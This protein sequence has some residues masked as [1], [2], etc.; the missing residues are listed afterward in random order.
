MRYFIFLI[1]CFV[2]NSLVSQTLI[3]SQPGTKIQARDIQG[4]LL[5]LIYESDI[6]DGI[7]NK[8]DYFTLDK[9]NKVIYFHLHMNNPQP[10]RDLL[11]KIDYSGNSLVELKNF[12]SPTSMVYSQKEN[13]IYY[14]ISAG[15]VDQVGIRYFDL[16]D[17]QDYLLYNSLLCSNLV[18]DDKN[19]IIYFNIGFDPKKIN[20]NGQ[21]LQDVGFLVNSNPFID[22]KFS[23]D[24]TNGDLYLA[25]SSFNTNP[26]VVKVE[27]DGVFRDTLFQ[28]DSNIFSSSYISE[29]PVY[30][31]L[32]NELYFFLRQN[33]I[34]TSNVTRLFLRLNTL[35]S[36]IDTL[37]SITYQSTDNS[38][39]I[40]DWDLDFEPALI[41]K[42]IAVNHF[43]LLPNN[44][45]FDEKFFLGSAITNPT[46]FQEFKICTD[47]TSASVLEISHGFNAPINEDD[48]GIR[49][50]QDPN[51]TNP[52]EYGYF[53]SITSISNELLS[54]K[55]TH[56]EYLVSSVMGEYINVEIVD[57]KTD[58]VR[59]TIPLALYNPPVLLIH[60]LN[61]EGS[62]FNELRNYLKYPLGFIKQPSYA[63]DKEFKANAAVLPSNIDDL[64]LNMIAD[65]YS[66]GKVDIIGHSMGGILSRLYLQSNYY[67]N[68]INKLVCLNTPHSG[69]ELAN[70][71]H[72]YELVCEFIFEYF[73]FFVREFDCLGGA[74]ENLRTNS[75]AIQQD[76]NGEKLNRETTPS[77]SI[78]TT[79]KSSQLK[80]YESIL[81][82]LILGTV[83]FDDEHDYIV[84]KSSQIGGLD[85]ANQSEFESPHWGSYNHP[86]V[87]K[88]IKELL[89][90]N[91][92]G[93]LFAQNGFNPV[94]LNP[95]A[96]SHITS[97]KVPITITSSFEN[98]EVNYGETID[99]KINPNSDVDSTILLINGI[100]LV[101]NRDSTEYFNNGAVN[102]VRKIETS[103][104]G[105]LPIT[106]YSFNRTENT[107]GS[108]TLFVSVNT[109]ES[110]LRFSHGI[111]VLEV[112]NK[113]KLPISAHFQNYTVGI[114][115]VSS[116]E[117]DFKHGLV[118]YIGD[119]YV[120]PIKSG[121]DTLTVTFNNVESQ[122]I[123]IN[124]SEQFTS[125]IQEHIQNAISNVNSF[126]LKIYPNPTADKINIESSIERK[127]TF[128][129]VIVDAIGNLVLQKNNFEINPEISNGIDVSN[130]Q[131]GVYS[132]VVFNRDQYSTITFVKQK[133]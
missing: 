52:E 90:G 109:T 18:I 95:Q 37:E 2:T 69:S 83:L 91:P 38:K 58:E 60:G 29:A 82:D 86:L 14:T 61:S 113:I 89:L 130:L 53:S 16:N 81:I 25:E 6:Q 125:S 116:L 74:F 123:R 66:A 114:S 98:K 30:D 7:N 112:G 102:I 105:R 55:Y 24:Q 71:A 94:N 31:N 11:M 8:I 59:L 128:W 35:T 56:P 22:I 120:L 21:N 132:I 32:N 19:S 117:Y 41:Q 1:I 79:V 5:K 34:F 39:E 46:E 64:L 77:H 57:N 108:D 47:G 88:R 99:I 75:I 115:D 27:N 111:G 118:E 28:I 48:Y 54:V 70:L 49:I 87:R 17:N 119:G 100:G 131:N 15:T 122:E 26:L 67:L 76:L 36:S 13:R 96:V 104:L 126:E 51:S 93:L 72:T 80:F 92:R 133:N 101:D 42:E 121:V 40:I 50:K 23:I 45:T 4:E 44:P 73:F 68:D 9:V 127:E 63:N 84:S 78:I 124:I 103:E 62:I 85:L 33:D 10:Q 106:A 3:W 110:P 12:F 107:W 43:H 97:N 20:T 65:G 129:L